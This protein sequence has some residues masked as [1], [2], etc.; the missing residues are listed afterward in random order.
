M[1]DRQ[2]RIL[3]GLVA[4]LVLSFIVHSASRS[5]G[6]FITELIE[7]YEQRSYD[8]RMRSKASFSEEGSIDQVV[9]VDIDLS[10][11]EAMGNYYDWPHAYHGQLI[12]VL[13]SGGP[14]AILFDIIFDPKSTYEHELVDALASGLSGSQ[15]DLQEAADQYLVNNDPYRLV[16]STY[17]SPQ[18]HHSLVIEHPDTVNYLYAM[19]SIPGAYGAAAH[20]L[21]LPAHVAERLPTGERIGN[22]HFDL[23]NASHHMGAANFPPDTDGIIRR[24]PTAIHFKG[25][26]D[27]FPSITMSAAMDILN[28]PPDGFDY[29]LDHNLLRLNDATGATV[30]EI[31]VDDQGRIP[32][33]YFGSFKTFTYI[34]YLYCFDPE[35]LDP[36][37]WEGKV[38]IV[39]S[40]LAGLGDLKSTSV[41]RSF[42]GPEIH[43]NV[44]HSI[45]QDDFVRPVSRSTNLWAMVVLSCVLGMVCGV[46][47]RPFWGFGLLIIFGMAWVVYT[48]GQFLSHGTMWDVV[49]PMASLTLTQLSVFSFTFLVMDRDKRFLRD[50]FGTY[51]SP[52]LIEQ[53]VEDKEE[54]KLGGDEAVHTAFFTD[55]Q[56]F[57]T[58][59]EQLTATDLVELLNIYLTDM[60]TILLNN[61]GTLDKYI[62]DAIVAFF[63][64]PVPL[65]DHALRACKT[66]LEIQERLELLRGKWID[67]GDRWPE[68]VRTMQN[69]IGI[70][71]GPMVTGNMGSD[72]RMNYT[73]MGD[74]VNLAA[75]LESSCRYYGIYTQITE[76]TYSA[77]KE[78]VVVR[79]MDR[80][81]VLGKKEPVTTYEL[82]S[83]KG[84]QPDHMDELLPGFAE[85]LSLY[86]DREWA[87]ARDMFESLEAHERMVPGR[88]TN[89][90]RVYAERCEQYKNDPPPEDWGGVTALTAK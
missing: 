55:V 76:D 35:M 44:I 64:A 75:R 28:I 27:V 84:E 63:G 82:V 81:I 48:T 88:K 53:M 22:L 37:Y 31:P 69:R 57:S 8:G 40:S 67:D 83:L 54:P 5:P 12:D 65:D 6:S 73:M 32:V 41:Q 1:S 87:R 49:R 10:S 86:R 56:D 47:G 58:I 77:V 21:D 34:P 79:E 60:T 46:P 36:S 50:T 29:D 26:G 14:S 19:D 72:Q 90:C 3:V 23:L 24:A 42:P 17:E 62:G 11:I 39:G 59:S 16:Q 18:V 45:L 80:I 78:R 68:I 4:G 7:G 85:A 30:R 15:P 43:A 13:A 70:H 51:I 61:Q 52:E 2:K 66:A 33:N 38:A 74:A 20:V 9:I 89:P 71:S 25:S